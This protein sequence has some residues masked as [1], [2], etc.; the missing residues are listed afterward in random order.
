MLVAS[1][2]VP[3]SFDKVLLG[4]NNHSGKIHRL[5]VIRY[6]VIIPSIHN[7]LFPCEM[8]VGNG[9]SPLLA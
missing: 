8:R 4:T 3:R 7:N 5:M 6:V 1:F 9:S 2:A